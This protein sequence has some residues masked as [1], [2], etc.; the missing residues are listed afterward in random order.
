MKSTIPE[1][2]SF[3]DCLNPKI[4]LDP[5]KSGEYSTHLAALVSGLNYAIEKGS[6][7]SPYISKDVAKEYYQKLAQ[8]CENSFELM[9]LSRTL[10]AEAQSYA[11]KHILGS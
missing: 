6:I 3:G 11:Y 1:V 8:K 10:P 2:I 5:N 7:L 9:V 4:S